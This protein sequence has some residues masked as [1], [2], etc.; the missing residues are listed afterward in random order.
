ML[1]QLSPFQLQVLMV[2]REGEGLTGWTV[3]IFNMMVYFLVLKV[4]RLILQPRFLY[5][6]RFIES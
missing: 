3:R 2:L 1:T 6:L 5:T 4:F